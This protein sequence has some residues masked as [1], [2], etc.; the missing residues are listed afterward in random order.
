MSHDPATLDVSTIPTAQAG[1]LALAHGSA[2]GG[3]DLWTGAYTLEGWITRAGK[4]LPCDRE[5]LHGLVAWLALGGS[6][7]TAELR[8][9]RM[10]WL[11]I[12]D[13]GDRTCKALNQAQQNALFD[14]C[15]A[16]ELDYADTLTAIKLL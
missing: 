6:Q 16:M 5:M 3:V 9:E 8:A 14:Y 10:G 1:S 2:S 15:E 4:F 13:Y 7:D 12:S 11:R